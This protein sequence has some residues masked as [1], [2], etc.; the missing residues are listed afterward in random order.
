MMSRM[1]TLVEIPRLRPSVR[2]SWR[3]YR[4]NAGRLSS[5]HHKVEPHSPA[6]HTTPK[7]QASQCNEQ[8]P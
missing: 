2:R 3:A 8:L 1:G 7:L 4:I 5:Y 6:S